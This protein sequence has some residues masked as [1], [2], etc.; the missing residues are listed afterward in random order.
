MVTRSAGD[1]DPI[2]VAYL[3]LRPG[4]PAFGRTSRHFVPVDDDVNARRPQ[5][6]GQG[7]DALP[8]IVAIV[9][10]A[11]EGHLNYGSSVFPVLIPNILGYLRTRIAMAEESGSRTHQG[12]ALGPLRI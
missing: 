1:Q 8:V 7:A 9:T 11:D 6:I 4:R 3:V 5:L 10:V 2:G 12:P